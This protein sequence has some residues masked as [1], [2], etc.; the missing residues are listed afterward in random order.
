[1]PFRTA[2]KQEDIDEKEGRKTNNVYSLRHML[3]VLYSIPTCSITHRNPRFASGLHAAH[4]SKPKWMANVGCCTPIHCRND[5]INIAAKRPKGP[6]IHWGPGADCLVS[7]PSD[8]A[9]SQML[10]TVV[11]HV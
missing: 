4:L 8:E 3:A 1:M 2:K 7:T 6:V 5:L 11:L 9:T 10:V